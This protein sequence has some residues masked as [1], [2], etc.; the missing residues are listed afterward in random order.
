MGVLT[1]PTRILYFNQTNQTFL[2]PLGCGRQSG[3][4]AELRGRKMTSCT[5]ACGLS[6]LALIHVNLGALN[7]L[8]ESL[9]LRMWDTH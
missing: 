5:L 9:P 2:R 4:E 3:T 1:K 6:L 7:V 8:E